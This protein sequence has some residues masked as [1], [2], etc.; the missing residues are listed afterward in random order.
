[1]PRVF[2]ALIFDEPQKKQLA[3]L[4]RRIEPQLQQG[5]LCRKDGL[6][7]TLQ[8]IGEV[9]EDQLPTLQRALGALEVTL[10][11]LQST[12]L[13][14]FR[15]GVFSTLYLG[16]ELTPE[17]SHLHHNVQDAICNLGLEIKTRR[18]FVPHVT[19]ARKA[20]FKRDALSTLNQQ[21]PT[22]EQQAHL[23]LLQ[24]EFLPDGVIYHEIPLIR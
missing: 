9:P 4:M 13:S 11:T 6:H 24:T 8:F 17:L 20:R 18:S 16:F 5:K 2:V 14:T 3:D 15:S 19:L 7:I 10:F 22:L 21:L 1:M 12:Q 23:V